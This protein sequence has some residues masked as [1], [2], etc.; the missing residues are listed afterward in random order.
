MMMPNERTRRIT[1]SADP[2][3]TRLA[4]PMMLLVTAID[5]NSRPLRPLV[6][7]VD[8]VESA[9]RLDDGDDEYDEVD[10]LQHR[11]HHMEE[12]LPLRLPRR[13]QPLP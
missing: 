4:S 7:D 1:A 10:R 12:G 8:D 9:E 5:N 2:N 11:E 3:P 13:S 6:R